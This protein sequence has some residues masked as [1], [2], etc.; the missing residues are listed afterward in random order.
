M[1]SQLRWRPEVIFVV[2]PTLAGA[3]LALV[4]AKA[5]GAVSWLHV[6]DFEIDAAFELGLM[7]GRTL[8]HIALS[9]EQR[10]MRAFDRVSSISERMVEKAAGKGTP[11]ARLVFFPNWVDTEAITPDILGRSMR[12]ELGIPDS[13]IVALYSGTM[14]AKQGLDL[15][16]SAAR[17]LRDAADIRF[18]FCGDGPGR[19][20]LADRCAGLDSVLILHLQAIDRLPSLLGMADIHLMPQQAGAADLV[21]P[22]KLTGMMASGRPTVAT[23]AEGTEMAR[24]VRGRGLIVPPGDTEQFAA[25]IQRLADDFD[26]RSRLGAQARAYALQH[27]TRDT[28]LSAFE[29]AL[30]SAVAAVARPS[31]RTS[32]QALSR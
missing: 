8:R 22:S 25:A 1:A 9:C 3:P 19:A 21:M 2:E 13:A 30:S 32:R 17:R 14:G 27:L 29:D 16:S 18:V 12:D 24:V 31:A 23:C 5:C 15:L 6:Q 20:E 26:L 10:L 11:S 4:C 7:R 28:V